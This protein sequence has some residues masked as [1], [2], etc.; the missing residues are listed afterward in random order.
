[1]IIG[2]AGND[3][4]CGDAGPTTLVGGLGNDRLYGG[5]NGLVNVFESGDEPAGDTLVPGPGD[6]LV[7]A[8]VNTVLR[9]DG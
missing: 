7:D 5:T 4:V 3:L 1:M 9:G 6:D 8:G 2:G